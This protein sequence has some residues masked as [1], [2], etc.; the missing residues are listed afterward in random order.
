MISLAVYFVASWWGTRMLDEYGFD[1]GML[2][3]M[4]AGTFAFIVSTAIG[5]GIDWAFPSQ[6]ISMFSVPGV[7]VPG[8]PAAN[9]PS[10]KDVKDVEDALKAAAK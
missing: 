2:R 5:Y 6:A 1:K 3:K 8:Q 4:L 9:D 7:S 10:A